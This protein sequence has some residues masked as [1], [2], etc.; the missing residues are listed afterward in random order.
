MK[1]IMVKFYSTHFHYC[2]TTTLRARV[3]ALSMLQSS[4]HNSNLNSNS[5]L[6]QP[7][8]KV[9]TR[10]YKVK[11]ALSQDCY[12]LEFALSE[13]ELCG[14]HSIPNF[15]YELY[16]ITQDNSNSSGKFSNEVLLLLVPFFKMVF[17]SL[18]R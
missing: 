6:L 5:R 1:I 7:V 16:T 14:L 12:N 13:F 10:L 15:N 18:R 9:F 8:H 2:N 17:K 3:P 4:P 11:T